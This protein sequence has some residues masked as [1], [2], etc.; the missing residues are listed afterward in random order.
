MRNIIAKERVLFD[1]YD[2]DNYF[3]WAE[4]CLKENCEDEEEFSDSEIEE[5][6]Y[7]LVS[8]DF[9]IIVSELENFF[10]N[11]EIICFGS[12]GRWN[13]VY[14]GGKI[15]D[16]FKNALYS[17]IEDCWYYKI[18]DE[19]GHLFVHCS[20]H[21][22]SCTFEIKVLNDK[23]IKYFDNWNYSWSDNRSEKEVH[24]QIIKRYSV[25]PNL[26]YKVYGCPKIE[27]IEAT[28]TD[29]QNKLNNKARS[30]YS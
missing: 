7:D 17:M 11:N 5:V 28:K 10:K 12:I 30:F 25:L 3:K 16:D 20:H 22:G 1:N 21:D 23:G 14:S 2:M 27:N 6:A 19:N 9:D 4:E 29:L 24:N 8:Q 18:Y 13:G 15:F 26:M